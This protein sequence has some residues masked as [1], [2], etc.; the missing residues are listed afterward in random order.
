MKTVEMIRAIKAMKL[1]KKEDDYEVYEDD[2]SG[3]LFEIDYDNG[4]IIHIHALDNDGEV[5]E[6]IY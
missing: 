2:A 6:T 3:A 4:E 1:I 5:Q